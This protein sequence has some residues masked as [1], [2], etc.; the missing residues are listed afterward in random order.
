MANILWKKI[1]K[2]S[3]INIGGGHTGKNKVEAIEG[4]LLG[5]RS[6]QGI[7]LFGGGVLPLEFF[8][9]SASAVRVMHTLRHM[10]FIPDPG[11][12]MF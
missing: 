2:G 9:S 5:S 12:V 3:W 11:A 7:A 8:N 4:H 1:G 6:R 10:G